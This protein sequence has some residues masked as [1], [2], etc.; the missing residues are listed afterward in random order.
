MPAFNCRQSFRDIDGE[1][2][3]SGMALAPVIVSAS[4][5]KLH[6]AVRVQIDVDPYSF[7]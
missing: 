3:H 1:E 2:Y 7:M 6:S 4:R 5:V